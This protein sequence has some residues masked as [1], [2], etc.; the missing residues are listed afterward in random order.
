MNELLSGL[1]AI[2][3]R[4]GLAIIFLVISLVAISRA[5]TYRLERDVAEGA[6]QILAERLT[7]SNASLEECDKA[8]SDITIEGVARHDRLA[9]AAQAQMKRAE[10][11]KEEAERIL[12]ETPSGQCRTPQSILDSE[13]L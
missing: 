6:N 1:K 7:L 2:G 9:M 3:I 11:L 10:A 8:L 4:G 12:R 5:N 13:N